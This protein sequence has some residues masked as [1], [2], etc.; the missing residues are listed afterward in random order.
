MREKVTNCLSK[1]SFCDRLSQLLKRGKPEAKFLG[2]FSFASFSLAAKEKK[3]S[4]GE[5]IDSYPS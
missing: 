2:G 5:T 3:N 4:Y 1:A